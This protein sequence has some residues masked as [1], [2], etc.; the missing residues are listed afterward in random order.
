[1]DAPFTLPDLAFVRLRMTMRLLA[2]ARLPAHKG[3]LFRGGFGYAFQRATCPEGCW[4]HARECASETICPYRWVFETPHPPGIAQ[5]HNLQDVPRPFA[6]RLPRDQRTSY[7]AGETLEFELV[8]IGR[9]L[10][11]LPFFIF[12]FARLGEIGLGAG[13]SRARLERAEALEAWNPVGPVVYQDGRVVD[14]DTLP[15]IDG[16]AILARAQALPPDLRLSIETPL[17]VKVGGALIKQL[18]LPALIRAT[19]WRL[20]ALATFHGGGPWQTNQRGLAEQAQAVAVEQVQ[21]CW[22]EWERRSDHGAGP[23]KIQMGG[24]VGS[25]VLRAVPVALRAVLL[26]GTVA[27]VGKA[28]V[29]GNGVLAVEALR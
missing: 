21:V 6:L 2:D 15:Q 8:I 9:G 3:A 26:A 4:G 7:R 12:G 11:Y 17:Q 28:S 5:L 14:L 29:F 25:A 18:E 22:E 1:M 24:I 10:D 13:R 19:A 23:Q 16:A 20:D 27:N